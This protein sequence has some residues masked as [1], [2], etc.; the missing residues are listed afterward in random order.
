MRSG[1]ELLEQPRAAFILS[2]PLPAALARAERSRT[3]SAAN[4]QEWR[5]NQVAL[6]RFRR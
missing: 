4:K 6:S 2:R 1:L 5:R 3:D